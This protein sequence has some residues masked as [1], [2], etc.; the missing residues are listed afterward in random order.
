MG[1]RIRRRKLAAQNQHSQQDDETV[2]TLRIE[3]ISTDQ[4]ER[5]IDAPRIFEVRSTI[6]KKGIPSDES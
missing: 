2:T 3:F 1:C 6:L 4:R 5:V